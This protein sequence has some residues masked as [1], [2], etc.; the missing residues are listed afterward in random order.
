MASQASIS[1]HQPNQGISAHG[2]R[3]YLG[4]DGL[5][6]LA[7]VAVVLFHTRPSMLSGGFLGVTVF[8]VMTGFLSTSSI[9]HAAAAGGFRYGS[10]VLKRFKRLWPMVLA[11]IALTIPLVYL[12]SPSLLLKARADALPAATFAINW[13]Y[14]FRKVPY[15]AAAGLPSPLTP[16]WFMAII[17]QFAVLWP[18]ILMLLRRVCR[19]RWMLHASVLLLIILSCAAMIVLSY[20]GDDTAHLYYGLDTRA[21]ELLIGAELALLLADHTSRADAKG[22]SASNAHK[23]AE[24]ETDGRDPA[25][26]QPGV[27]HP[28]VNRLN[29]R[30]TVGGIAIGMTDVLALIALVIL[31]AGAVMVDGDTLWMYRG[32][33]QIAALLSALLVW[34]CTIP[35]SAAAAILGCRPLV[36]AGSRAFA[37]YIIHFPLLEIMNPATRTTSM[38]WWGW[39]LQFAII[40]AVAELIHRFIEV[41]AHRNITPAAAAVKHDVKPDDTGQKQPTMAAVRPVLARVGR[42]VHTY[43]I[44]VQPVAKVMAAAG[45][46]IVFIACCL[47]LDWDGIVEQRSIELRPEIAE[48]THL[49]GKKSAAGSAGQASVPSAS[50][51][52][53][54]SSPSSKSSAAAAS[55]SQSAQPTPSATPKQPKMS[56]HAEK[57]PAGVPLSSWTFDAATGV[58]SADPLIIGDSVALG[59]ADII[60]QIL[61][62]AV[63]DA[64]VSRQIT[65]APGIYAQHA[66]AGQGGS[67][68]VIALGDNGPIRDEAELQGIVDAMGGKPVYF[69][70]LRVPVSWQDPNNAVLRSFAASHRNVGIIDWYGTSEGHSEYLYDDGTHLTPQGRPAYATML[71]QAFCGQ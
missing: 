68:V 3:R 2:T 57:V 18:A 34:A 40:A 10:Y 60:Q 25:A 45:L 35:G 19:S 22:A 7:I 6:A 59:A 4:I 17:M 24:P 5:R 30:I 53:H 62:N 21:A 67:V 23:P 64:Q 61:P 9:E 70:T 8:F 29:R 54:A 11:S 44:D 58:C 13:V 48:Q 15:F 56:A 66:G 49:A 1:E 52:A 39:L 71:R 41:P 42:N 55:P 20:R 50:P 31:V 46:V 38:P 63:V 32:G 37:V 69:L 26:K 12:F 51:S 16:L 28:W 27:N 65:T 36:V 43:L 14:I 47:P 33:Y